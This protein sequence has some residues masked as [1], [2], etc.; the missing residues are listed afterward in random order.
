M[1][2][3]LIPEAT[4]VAAKRGFIRT[5]TQALSTSIPASGI[6]GAALSGGDP[7]TIAWA[8]GA[9]AL[10]SVAAGAVSYFSILSKGI[11]EDYAAAVPPTTA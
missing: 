6:T 5:T 3:E 7:V 2:T 10:S 4:Q 11:P 8:V 9:A 1:S